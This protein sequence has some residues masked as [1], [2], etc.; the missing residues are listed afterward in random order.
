MPFYFVKKRL[1]E[2][3]MKKW[4]ILLFFLLNNIEREWKDEKKKLSSLQ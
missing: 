1:I 4:V 3:Y 2:S